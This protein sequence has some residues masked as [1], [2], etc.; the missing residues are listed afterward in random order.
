MRSGKVGGVRGAVLI[1]AL[2][3]AL[4]WSEAR[5]GFVPIVAAPGFDPITQSGYSSGSVVDAGA[6]HA[7]GI[8]L[9]YVRKR[10]AGNVDKGHRA[11]RWDAVGNA[12]ELQILGTNAS[13]VTEVFPYGINPAGFA[14]GTVD[15]YVNNSNVGGRPV[16]WDPSGNL[17]ELQ[18]LA[19]SSSDFVEGRPYAVNRTGMAGGYTTKYQGSTSLGYRAVRWDAAGNVTDLGTLG[20][21]SA[22]SGESYVSSLNDAGEGVG[23]AFKYVGGVFKGQRAARWGVAGTILEL[24][25]L[26][27]DANGDS[28]SFATDINNGGVAV[29]S[30]AR[31]AGV[32][33]GMLPVR[34]D[35]AGNVTVLSTLGISS[36]GGASGQPNAIN[37]AGVAA[38][39]STKYVGGAHKGSRAARWDASG[40]ITELGNLGADSSGV[41]NSMAVAMD[42]SGAAV[43]WAHR[44]TPAGVNLGRRA[45]YWAADGTTVDLNTLIDPDSGWVLSEA[46]GI[47]EQEN[48]I[49]GF[50]QFDPD[51]ASGPLAS[52]ERAF[53]IQ[54]PEPSGVAAV[55][56]G[57]WVL[58]SRRG[59]GGPIGRRQGACGG[60]SG[61]WGGRGGCRGGTSECQRFGGGNGS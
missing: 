35:P 52:Y 1:G 7:S 37:D 9:A 48:W 47:S 39:Q 21:N 50:G 4:G 15:K 60:F 13:G 34:W 33:T 20:T 18:T 28:Q 46:V 10:S 41:T 51:G 12:V 2:G 59:G 23:T 49:A 26:G 61:R 27:E 44:F 56:A 14:F 11:V 25:N 53:L 57:V 24:Q 45:V 36:T 58:I 29:G 16:R 43:G 22:G 38:G 40:N 6:V 17:T 8:A 54:V 3:T 42:A 19:P 32:S 30:A 5:A 31:F 55:F